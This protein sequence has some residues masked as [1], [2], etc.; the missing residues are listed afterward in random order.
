MQESV[1]FLQGINKVSKLLFG[2]FEM[3]FDESQVSLTRIEHEMSIAGFPAEDEMRAE[4]V[5]DSIMCMN[6]ANKI[7]KA[8]FKMDGVESVIVDV[9]K[10]T[11]AIDF[12]KSKSSLDDI[13]AKLVEIGHPAD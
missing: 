9:D 3:D 2:A 10:K 11:V 4:L 1:G 13:K 7:K 8:I 5:C 6:C 12:N